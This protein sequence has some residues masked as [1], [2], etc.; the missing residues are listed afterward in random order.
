MTAALS[1]GVALDPVYFFLNRWYKDRPPG[2]KH[3]FEKHADWRAALCDARGGWT[4]NTH[5]NHP[6]RAS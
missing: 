1:L 3:D 4:R 2:K 6:L 5:E